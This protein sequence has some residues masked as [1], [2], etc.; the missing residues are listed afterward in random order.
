VPDTARV[1]GLI[2]WQPTRDLNQIIADV[3]ADISAR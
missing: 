1:R 3:A 2:G